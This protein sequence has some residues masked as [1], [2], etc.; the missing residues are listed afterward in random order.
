VHL[1]LGPDAVVAARKKLERFGAEIAAWEAV[2][3]GTDFS[4]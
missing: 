2:S 3:S 1:L 4:N